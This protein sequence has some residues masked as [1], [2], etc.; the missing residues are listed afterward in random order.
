MV[1][2]L[3][4]ISCGDRLMTVDPEQPPDAAADPEPPR[5]AAIADSSDAASC[6]PAQPGSP[7]LATVPPE[8]ERRRNPIPETAE[9][10]ASGEELFAVHCVRCHGTGGRGDGAPLLAPPPADLTAKLHGD[11][12]VFWRISEGGLGNPTCSAMPSFRDALDEDTRWRLVRRVQRF[13]NRY[14]AGID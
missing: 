1:L 4:G 12:Y 6:V 10:L 7:H 3:A 14:D 5:D 11:G 13:S 2:V 9:T 8:Y